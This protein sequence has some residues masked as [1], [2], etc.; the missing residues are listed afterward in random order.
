MNVMHDVKLNI[1]Y[2]TVVINRPGIWRVKWWLI[3]PIHNNAEKL[4]TTGTPAHG[5]SSRSTHHIKLLYYVQTHLESL[6]R[7]GYMFTYYVMNLVNFISA[8][9]FISGDFLKQR[10]VSLLGFPDSRWV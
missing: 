10:W 7:R 6:R 1:Q 2:M 4:K 9:L 8:F 3:L 5:Y